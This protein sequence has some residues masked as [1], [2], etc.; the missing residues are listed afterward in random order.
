MG[1]HI[2]IAG[3]RHVGKSTLLNRLT[4][5]LDIPFY[6]FRTAPG[7]SV[8]S[9]CRSFY[10]HPA[11]ECERFETEENHIGDGGRSGPVGCP[12]VFDTFGIKCLEAE[13]GGLIIMDEL[14]FFEKDAE[15][16]GKRVLEL[17]DGDIPVIATAKTGHD[18][19]LLNA[20]FDHP[21][22]DVYYITEENRDELYGL[23]SAEFL[24]TE[25]NHE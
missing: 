14:G 23:L 5:G 6:G 13:P 4:E 24:R 7:K 22:A 9:G 10:M 20:I 12:D 18:L 17:L 19:G 25:E 3:K 2:I 21:N 11:A 1:R 8:R 16:F 15:R